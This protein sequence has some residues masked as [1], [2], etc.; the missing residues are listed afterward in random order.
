MII[1]FTLDGEDINGAVDPR[2]GRAKK[3]L[4]YDTEQKKTQIVDNRQVLDAAQGAGIQ[5]AQNLINHKVKALITGNIG[6]KAFKVLSAA[7]IKVYQS[8]QTAVKEALDSYLQ[9]KLTEFSDA[10]VEGHW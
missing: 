6:P 4:L 2:F 10:N 5:A 9:G 1:A 8:H 3:F 7:G